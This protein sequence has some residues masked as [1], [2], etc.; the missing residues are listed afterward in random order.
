MPNPLF[1]QPQYDLRAFNCPHCKAYSNMN[2][3]EG[4]GTW[5]YMAGGYFDINDLELVKCA[6]CSRYSIW[7]EESMIYPREIEVESPNEDL[8]EEVKADY[9]EAALI[10]KD[11]PRG[12]GALLR[13][14]IQKLCDSL[15]EGND[16][17][18]MK[19]GSLVANGLDKKIQQALDSVRVIGNEAVHPGQIDL[20]DSP[21]IV[22]QLFRLIN[23]IGRRMITEPKE[24]EDIYSLLPPS[25]I[26]GI[27]VRDKPKN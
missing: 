5:K 2:W 6:H 8:P 24:V 21:E 1:I 9:S 27:E 3:I 16:D 12:A 10:L 26:A 13:L 25:K 15:V 11:S 20:N 18:N 19:I 22:Y 17:L 23:L 7:F 4:K 14:A